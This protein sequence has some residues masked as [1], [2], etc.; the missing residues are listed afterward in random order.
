MHRI[1]TDSHLDLIGKLIWK[2]E[3]KIR[4]ECLDE[5]RNDRSLQH[6]VHISHGS[7]DYI[8]NVVSS[9]CYASTCYRFVIAGGLGF[10]EGRQKHPYTNCK[11]GQCTVKFVGLIRDSRKN[12]TLDILALH[13]YW[14]HI[15]RLMPADSLVR[16]VRRN[17]DDTEAEILDQK[18]ER[19][20]REIPLSVRKELPNKNKK[21][22][23]H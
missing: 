18:G 19:E 11:G 3:E 20:R 21:I 17:V 14:N 6:N 16:V 13:Q 12:K 2:S 23:D 1:R 22:Y 4:I 9:F 15:A 8:Y 7:S 5:K 10:R